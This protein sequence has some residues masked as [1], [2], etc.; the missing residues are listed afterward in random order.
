MSIPSDYLLVAT[1]LA[2]SPS[3]L[4]AFVHESL[5]RLTNIS[6][7]VT[8]DDVTRNLPTSPPTTVPEDVV[9]ILIRQR[10]LPA[11]IGVN[12]VEAGYVVT[13][14]ASSTAEVF[15]VLFVNFGPGRACTVEGAVEVRYFYPRDADARAMF[16]AAYYDDSVIAFRVIEI[17]NDS[18]RVED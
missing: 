4:E 18:Q 17:A 16:L 14:T 7:P 1:H 13:E 2:H 9:A 6:I 8:I 11:T 15:W 3:L 5:L 12:G 10:A